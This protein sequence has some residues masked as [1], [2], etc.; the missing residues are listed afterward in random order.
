MRSV[1]SV[2]CLSCAVLV[3]AHLVFGQAIEFQSNP[4]ANGAITVEAGD[5]DRSDWDGIPWFEMDDD[6]DQ[7][8]PV[9]IDGVQMAHDSQYL[10]IH[11]RAL[12]WD[13]Q[14]D[15]RIG[16]YIDTDG[17]FE[18]GYNGNFLA[19]A[20]EFLL[21]GQLYEFTGASTTDWSWSQVGE[22][23]RDQSDWKDVEVA[24]PRELF[25]DVEEINFIMYANNFCCDFGLPDDAYPNEANVPFGAYFTYS[26]AA[27]PP[28]VGDFDGSGSLD[29]ADIDL[30]VTQMNTVP[31]AAA[32]DLNA[33]GSVD[34]ADLTVWVKDLKGTW[35]GD[36]DLNGEFSS[37]DFVVIFTAGKFESEMAANWREGDW[38]GDQRFSSSDLVWAFQDGGFELGP[39]AAVAAVPEPQT[40]AWLVLAFGLL[41]RRITRR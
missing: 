16:T 28:L 7:Y 39:R 18:I 12:E 32:Y 33:D 36:S 26:F 5:V 11:Q 19:V 13:V 40:I 23:R 15:W 27:E 29:L 4:V 17:D 22:L 30:L 10:Y 6:F 38:N 20:A 25:G 14:E 34:G 37:A 8:Y 3:N 35:F 9:D 31:G 41:R 24:I 1:A 2:I 21:E